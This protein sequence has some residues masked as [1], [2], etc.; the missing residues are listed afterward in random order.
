MWRPQLEALQ[1]TFRPVAVDLRGHGRSPV[2]PGSYCIED[3]G[4]DVLDT[5]DELG[6]ERFSYVGLSLGGMV[7]MWLAAEHPARVDRLALI[8]T[9]AHMPPASDWRDRAARVRSFGMTAVADAVVSRWFTADFAAQHP[10]VVA[11]YVATVASAPADGYAACCEAIAEMD[12]RDRL[13]AITAP[14]LIVAGDHDPS[15]PL[16]HAE[17]IHRGI[18]DS[19]LQV[20]GPASHLA[21]VEA[22]EAVTSLVR[23]HLLGRTDPLSDVRQVTDER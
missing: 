11:A 13:P 14:T 4:Q 23:D 20:V 9:S 2:P 10:A 1:D 16:P 3:L 7:G 15:T 17:V 21:S 12:L 8:C 19:R 5:A 22:N 18:P 6:I